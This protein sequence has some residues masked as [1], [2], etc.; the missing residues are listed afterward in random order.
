MDLFYG[1]NDDVIRWF[2]S[3]LTNRKQQ[4]KIEDSVSA[5]K[6]INRGVPQGSVLGPLL[7]ILYINDIQNVVTSNINLF[8]DDTLSYISADSCDTAVNALNQDLNN[9]T[10]WLSENNL[11]LNAS[12]TKA[13]CLSL[14]KNLN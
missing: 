13:M 1:F 2:S 3:Y 11:A 14:R 5:P 7:F 9:L 8:A 6:L 4:T 10:S 12:K